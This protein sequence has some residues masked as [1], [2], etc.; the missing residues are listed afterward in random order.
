MQF[1]EVC[2]LL[3][4][5]LERVERM[6]RVDYV[7]KTVSD[8]ARRVNYLFIEEPIRVDGRFAA[9]ATDGLTIVLS[10]IIRSS[11][12][13]NWAILHE[14]GHVAIVRLSGPRVLM[15]CSLLRCTF[16][17]DP[18][19]EFADRVALHVAGVAGLEVTKPSIECKCRGVGVRDALKLGRSLDAC[20]TRVPRHVNHRSQ[21]RHRVS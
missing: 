4:A 11:A 7:V 3:A 16:T 18:I 9:A 21:I 15:L 12:E 1:E 8:L 14:L 17:G 19:E 5:V 13:L 10:G 2:N 6:R 20:I